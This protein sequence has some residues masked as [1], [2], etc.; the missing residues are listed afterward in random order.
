MS[1]LEVMLHKARLAKEPK[2]YREIIA[3]LEHLGEFIKVFLKENG[4]RKRRKKN[5]G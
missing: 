3:T 5:N 4:R 2:K 1:E